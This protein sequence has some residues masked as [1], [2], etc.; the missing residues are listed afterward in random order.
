[1]DTSQLPHNSITSEL[2]AVLKKY[3]RTEKVLI[4]PDYRIGYQILQHLARTGTPWVNLRPATVLSLAR[5]IAEDALISSNLQFVSIV[6]IQMLVDGIFRSLTDS[7]KLQYFKKHHVNKGMLEALTR[8]IRELRLSGLSTENLKPGYSINALKENDIRLILSEY[9]RI[10]LDKCLT[11]SEALVALALECTKKGIE[12]KNRT[13]LILSRHYMHGI[14]RQFLEKLCGDNLIVIKEDPVFGLSLP[15]DVWETGK[16]EEMPE[17]KTDIER[18][19]WLF[20]SRKASAPFGDGT[21]EIFSAVGHRNEAREIIHRIVAGNTPVDSVEII[22]TDSETY[23]DLFYSLCEK[24][25]IPVTFSEGIHGY[26]ANA[27][28]AMLGFLMWMREDFAEIYLRRI[29]ESGAVKHNVSKTTDAPGASILAFLLRT[30]GIGWGR[31][32]YSFIL[33]KKIKECTD[34]A[35]KLR[36]EGEEDDALYYETQAKNLPFLKKFCEDLLCLIPEADDSGKVDFAALCSGCVD[37][38]N[39]CVKTLSENDAAFIET[40]RERFR[41]LTGFIRDTIPFDEALEKI[42]SIISDIR[43]RA[44]APQPGHLHV[45]HYRNGGI[46]GRR[47]TFI[48]G[49]DEGKYPEK[50]TQDPVLLDEERVKLGSG[51]EISGERMRKNMFDM[52][53]LMSGLRGKMTVSFPAYDVNEDRKSFPSSLVLQVFRIKEGA[54]EADYNALFN[55]LG[56]PVGYTRGPA[57]TAEIDETDFWLNRLAAGGILKDGTE[58]VKTHYMGI[59]EG[60]TAREHRESVLVTEYDGK[61]T[62]DNARDLDPR[63]NEELVMSCSRLES[64]AKCPFL[65]FIKYVLG[66]SKP[67]EMVREPG[68]WLDPAQRGM[69]LHEVFQQVMEQMRAQRQKQNEEEQNALISKILDDTVQ[70]FKQDIPPPSEVVFENEYMQF[71][72]DVG[73][74]VLI[75]LQIGTEPIECEL[76]F[77]EKKEHAVKI[78]LGDGKNILLRGKIDRIDRAGNSE[79]HAWDYKTGKAFA[80]EENAYVQ[81]GEQIQH[82]LYAVAA[83]KILRQKYKDGTIKVTKSGYLLPTERGTKDGKGGIFPRSTTVKEAWQEPLGKLLDII[84]RGTFIVSKEALCT[85]CD[86]AGIC[87]GTTSK[88]QIKAKLDNPENKELDAW[89]ELKKYD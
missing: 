69:L 76:I 51:L 31:E 87:E 74:F 55:A 10:L 5:E 45:S 67:D 26:L 48:V 66:V 89:R 7:G 30:S 15:A 68:T 37:F 28:R 19:K 27:G 78:P 41:M 60:I 75:N 29:L 32:R 47:R 9:E 24:M 88:E 77:G 43:I 83:E 38:L 58:S 33:E 13:F 21:I 42:I 59:K 36:D 46:S 14:E 2:S 40:A 17:S 44:S 61:I 86:Y 82:S 52:A 72:R 53:G 54:P 84:G 65:Y 57:G 50:I 22:Y 8:T 70:R 25:N 16:K 23:G 20:G 79:Y 12:R 62:P 64:A 1:M 81:G 71:K 39:T 11:D 73:V 34:T 56:E 35:K 4:T 85:F 3:P 80:Y 6:G 63:E 49:L 18:L